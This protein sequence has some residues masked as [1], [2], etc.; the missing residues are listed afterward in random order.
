M[1]VQFTLSSQPVGFT[2]D[3]RQ[4]HALPFVDVAKMIDAPVLH[5]N[6]DDLKL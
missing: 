1:V 3:F 4:M 2:T 6:G 5:V